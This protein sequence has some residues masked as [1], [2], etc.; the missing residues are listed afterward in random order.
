MSACTFGVILR[1]YEGLIMPISIA[2]IL[3]LFITAADFAAAADTP[4]KTV[5]YLGA[6]LIDSAASSARPNTAVVTMGDR[7]VAVHSVEQY[8]AKPGDEVVDVRNKFIVPGLMNT[9][10]H[11]ATLAD[12]PVARAYL[13]RELYSGVTTV[14]DMAGDVRLLAEL[15]R[16]AQLGEVAS[17]D[18]YYV[19][20]MAG[21]GFFEDPRTH[22]AARGQIAG[23]VP[24]MQAI[25]PQTDLRLA[26]AR[27]RGAG[28]TAIKI[29]ADLP[30][31]LVRSITA[32]AH[33]Q[34]LLVWAHAAVFPALPS[35][36]VDAGVDVVSHACLLGFEISNPKVQSYEAVR[37]VDFAKLKQPNQQMDALF[38]AMKTHGTILDATLYTYESGTSRACPPGS[39]DYLA[40]EAYRAG[41]P[42]S[43]GTDDDPEWQDID[44]ELDTELEL[45]VSKVGM[46][47]SEALRSA[48]L[49]GARTAGLDQEIGSIE[50][51]KLANMLVLDRDPLQ[52]IANVR[53]V[54]FV[55]K[56]GIRYS[57]GDYRPATAEDFAQRAH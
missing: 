4:A 46:T 41:I 47:P 14:R 30:A 44:S 22:D 53:S 49:I 38:A 28:A 39:N 15:K 29:Y 17:P 57:R 43:A 42:L 8:A 1:A 18:I 52:N 19:A 45:L 5:V 50:A 35:E 32:E 9:H 51:G 2:V 34:H 11:L 37:P 56:R 3:C 31:P 13:R 48:T 36:V 40:R 26:V 23:Q 16:E 7:I 33:R 21:P 27:A 24:W 25:T 20:V 55:V 10:V 6:T 12:P 54:D